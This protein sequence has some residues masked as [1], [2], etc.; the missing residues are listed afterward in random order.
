MSALQVTRDDL[1]A[2]RFPVLALMRN[3]VVPRRP[4]VA[5]GELRGE[6]PVTPLS[7][8][9]SLIVDLGSDQFKV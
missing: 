1:E 6:W 2:L 7:C 3:V 4:F 9:V 5:S 8:G